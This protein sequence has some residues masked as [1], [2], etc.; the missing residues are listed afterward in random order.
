MDALSVI[1]GV[2]FK[3]SRLVIPTRMRSCIQDLL[4]IGHR[5]IDATLRHARD[6]VYDMT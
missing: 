5:G 4:H 3:E 6:I 1:D 2:I